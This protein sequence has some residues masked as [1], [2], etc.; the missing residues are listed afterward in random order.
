MMIKY[1][2]LND[3][4]E[5]AHPR[6]IDAL[7]RTNLVQEMG[8][9][10]DA[11]CQEAAG[12]IRQAVGNLQAAV[13]FLSGGTQTNLTVLSSFLRPFE[14]IIA[15]DSAHI[16][17][18]ETGAIEATGHKINRVKG[19]DGKV[20]VEEIA[21]TAAAHGD[22]HMVKP[23]VVFISH[24]TELGTLYSKKEL[25][26]I[27]VICKRLGLYLYLD[28]A[29]LGSALTSRF[30]DIS[31]SELSVLVDA[32]YIGGT[33]NGALLGEALV[34]NNEQLKPYFRYS[35]KQKGALLS[36]GRILGIQFLELF[37]DNLYFDLAKNANDM[38]EKLTEG[39]TGLGYLFQTTYRFY[40]WAKVDEQQSAVRLV[41]SWATE[42][43][44]VEEFV[45]DLRALSS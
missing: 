5:G 13:H 31:L 34:I 15:V 2:F 25:N 33:K 35:L 39:I 36:K 1:S 11:Y 28:G 43:E 3:Y 37:S 41:T 42:R 45:S 29:R 7:I 12:L 26:D 9:G 30:A 38:A 16:C 27:A 20:T 44:A 40:T 22:E 24:S 23:R 8:Y 4:S 17:V 32:F 14:S 10:E 19:Q 21:D 18:H 6:I